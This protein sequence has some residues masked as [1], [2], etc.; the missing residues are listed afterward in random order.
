MTASASG[1]PFIHFGMATKIIF[2]AGGDVLTLG[3]DLHSLGE[4]LV[5]FVEQERVVGAS[6]DDGVDER[7]L[8][9]QFI[10]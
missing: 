6:E 9:H 2:K 4:I 8:C 5:N 1:E 7:V 10:K 3:D